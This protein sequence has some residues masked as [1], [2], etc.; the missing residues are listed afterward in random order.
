LAETAWLSPGV[1][2]GKLIAAIHEREIQLQEI[3]EGRRDPSEITKLQEET[4]QLQERL[5]AKVQRFERRRIEETFSD[6]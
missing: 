6:L 4:A 2:I 5:A 3:K 1:A